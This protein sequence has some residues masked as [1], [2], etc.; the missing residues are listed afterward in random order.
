MKDVRLPNNQNIEVLRSVSKLMPANSHLVTVREAGKQ[1]LWS[2]SGGTVHVTA[3]VRGGE[4]DGAFVVLDRH[5]R[6]CASVLE[7]WE[8]AA[9]ENGMRPAC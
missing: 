4:F 8:I 6:A 3:Y 2:T 5:G 1:G 7:D 9:Q